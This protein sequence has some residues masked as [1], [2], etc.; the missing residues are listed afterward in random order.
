MSGCGSDRLVQFT[1][2]FAKTRLAPWGDD[3]SPF[4][5]SP[6]VTGYVPSS[7]K[8]NSGDIQ[9]FHDR[10]I[11]TRAIRGDQVVDSRGR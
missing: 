9:L 3:D 10:D 11:E 6:R 1:A 4:V 7:G 2:T 5:G 8:S